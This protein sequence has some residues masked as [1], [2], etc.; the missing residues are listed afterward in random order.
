MILGISLTL[1]IAISGFMNYCL[2]ARRTFQL[3]AVIA[4]AFG[5]IDEY[6]VDHESSW[7]YLTLF[8]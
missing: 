6:V 8:L 1:A 4:I 2:S 5:V 3:C 7:R